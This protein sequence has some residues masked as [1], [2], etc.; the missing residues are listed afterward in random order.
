MDKLSSSVLVFF[1]ATGD[2]A[3]KQIFPALQSMVRHGHFD[4][5]VIGVSGSD[6]T[7]EQLVARAKESVESHGG[8]DPQAF[9]KLAP[10]LKYLSGDYKKAET[11][12]RLCGMLGPDARPLFYLAIPPNMF[13]TV[14]THIAGTGCARHA[15]F[16]IEKP[17]G[18]DLA[19][20]RDLHAGL[21]QALPDATILL[22]D[23]YLGKEPVQN[24]LYFR[25]ANRFTEPVWNRDNVASVQI[26]MAEKFGV[27]GRE[28]FY[29]DVGAL[30]DVVQNHLLQVLA[31]LT[32]DAPDGR[33]P[34]S[35]RERKLE[36]F[37]AMRPLAPAEVV[38]GQFS[39]YRGSRDV[40][41]GS[42]VETF[43]AL[44][45]HIDTPRWQDVPFFIRAGKCLPVT[46]TEVTVYLK[47][48]EPAVFDNDSAPNYFRFRLSPDV[49]ISL[50][51]RV[52]LPGEA[53]QGES[54]ELAEHH[55]VGDE[56]S[57]YERLLGDALRGDASLFA[58]YESIEAAWRVIDPALGSGKVRIYDPGSWGPAEADALTAGEGGWHN[59]S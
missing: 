1:G 4:L 48:P 18:R 35:L 9:A 22:I 36:L 28:R 26:T 2:L 34:A 47:Q 25:F 40:A 32:I 46:A 14:V 44:R 59:P 15:R 23:H 41:P 43:A 42:E 33:D 3:K 7:D 58:E 13:T 16:I 11:Y 54:V 39:G 37:R 27:A 21:R 6:W 5:P 12:Q 38:R 56:M 31:L 55:Q 30:R 10:R 57:P 52:K 19:S 29:E 45:V 8:L 17:F 24:L 51:A 53:M 49:S 20:A 50:G